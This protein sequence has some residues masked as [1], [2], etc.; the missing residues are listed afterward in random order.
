MTRANSATPN[1]VPITIPAIIP[2]DKLPS[3]VDEE[4]VSIRVV[5]TGELVHPSRAVAPETSAL[6]VKIVLNVPL[7]TASINCA[8]KL[9]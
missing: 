9:E 2:S 1:M 4:D 8:D 6:I 5:V 3:S 7:L